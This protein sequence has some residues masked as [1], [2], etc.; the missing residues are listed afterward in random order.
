MY[1]SP[2]IRLQ[3]TETHIQLDGKNPM[4]SVCSETYRGPS[5][6]GLFFGYLLYSNY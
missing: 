4:A 6:I 2:K 3:E 1:I 5:D